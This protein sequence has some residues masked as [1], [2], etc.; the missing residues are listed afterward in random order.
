MKHYL[1]LATL[2]IGALLGSCSSDEVIDAPRESNLIGFK[3]MVNKTSR[4]EVTKDNLNRFR[5]FGCVTDVDNPTSGH[6]TLFN[7]V[8]VTKTDGVWTYKDEFKQYWSPN[9][10]YFFVA[11]STNSPTPVWE[12]TAPDTHDAALDK[13]NFYG[14][15]TVAMDITKADATGI[16]AN[17]ER[18]L[19]YAAATR[20]TPATVTDGS[21]VQLSFYH[22]LSRININFENAFTNNTYS[23]KVTNI[24]IGG[25]TQKGEVTLGAA[26]ADLA[27]S[28]TS[29][30]PVEITTIIPTGQE[31]I[32][33][34]SSQTA[35]S[36][37]IIPG[38][39]TIS[40]QFDVEVLQNGTQYAKKT[41]TGT[42]NA[43]EYKPGLSYMFTASISHTNIV[44]GG[45]L[46]IEFT[47]QQVAG[48][49]TDNSGDIN[50]PDTTE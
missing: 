48:W 32:A 39:Q 29:E 49:G 34:N 44:E 18:D 1:Y 31:T 8:M 22:M 2:A 46:P 33:Q 47:V 7:D 30:T 41:L 35:M 28:A 9:K 17:G 25:L 16:S 20:T 45:A 26:P 23:I 38:T 14:Y 5:V 11:I 40:I 24:K 10:D 43:Q 42:V 19:V 37:F 15:G 21:A 13:A 3:A 27:W 4:A 36:R 50:F 6:I 12:F